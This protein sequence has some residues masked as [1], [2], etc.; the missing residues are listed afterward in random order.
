MEGIE[1]NK[2]RILNK[3][4]WYIYILFLKRNKNNQGRKNYQKLSG[5]FEKETIEPL[6]N[7]KYN[8]NT[9]QKK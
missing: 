1:N 2:Y 3:Y 4:V 9:K 6:E 7:E 5:R 8:K